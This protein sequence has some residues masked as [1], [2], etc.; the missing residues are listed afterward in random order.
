MSI[1]NW[2]A[3]GTGSGACMSRRASE[4]LSNTMARMSP[5]LRMPAVPCMT[6]AHFEPHPVA[7]GFN[8]ENLDIVVNTR[9]GRQPRPFVL[10]HQGK[11]VFAQPCP[12]LKGKQGRSH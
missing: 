3:G 5:L 8:G 1:G 12:P 4:T 7:H 11:I 9:F 6:G 10:H 2:P